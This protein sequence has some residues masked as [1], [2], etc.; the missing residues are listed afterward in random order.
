MR[1]LAEDQDLV[2]IDRP[3]AG[4]VGASLYA[5]AVD[6]ENDPGPTALEYRRNRILDGAGDLLA[7]QR[8]S[9]DLG[10]ASVPKSPRIAAVDAPT[11]E[12]S[13]P[14]PESWHGKAVW[15]QVRTFADDRE[16]DTI[17][18]PVRV[19]V[20]DAGEITPSIMGTVTVTELE[21][22][23]AG[24][25]LV[26]F[27]FAASRDGIQPQAFTLRKATG[28]GTIADGTTPFI[29]GQ[30]IYELEVTG[31]TDAVAYTF[32]LLGVI[33]EAEQTLQP[34]IAFTADATGPPSVTGLVAVPV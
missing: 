12:F 14:V 20:D 7:Y 11:A 23:D 30:R 2:F 22:R 28:T 31:L 3:Y 25:L 19:L 24:G 18:R 26:R 34:A 4:G 16:H 8:T 15:L 27:V 33:G 21:K 10:A 1:I 29:S 6:P 9:F 32:D 17:Y 5:A 13:Y